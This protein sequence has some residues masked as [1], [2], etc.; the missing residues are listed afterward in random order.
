MGVGSP[1]QILAVAVYFVS[2]S[3]L[4]LFPISFNNPVDNDALFFLQKYSIHS[5]NRFW[6]NGSTGFTEEQRFALAQWPSSAAGPWAW[7]VGGHA[8]VR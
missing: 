2:L 7:T 8:S 5:H 4:S 6:F 3:L 1:K